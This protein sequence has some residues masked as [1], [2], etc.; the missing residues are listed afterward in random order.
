M[1]I[2]YLWFAYQIDNASTNSLKFF[3]YND[4]ITNL[5]SLVDSV[6]ILLRERMLIKLVYTLLTNS[7]QGC[8]ATVL[9][10]WTDGEDNFFAQCANVGDS[11]CI[12]RFVYLT[13]WNALV[14]FLIFE[15]V[16]GRKLD[17]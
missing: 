13:N 15:W 1:Q 7:L 16:K 9:L 4:P 11:T 5:F 14:A 10:V 2:L 8:T 6:K 12:M 3:L 17:N